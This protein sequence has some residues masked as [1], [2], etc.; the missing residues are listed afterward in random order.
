MNCESMT[1]DERSLLLYFEDCMV[2][3]MC[4]VQ[5]VHMNEEDFRIAEKWHEDKFV[6]FVRCPYDFIR[7]DNPNRRAGG[8]YTHLVLLSDEAW[9]LAHQL[10]EERGNRQFSNIVERRVNGELLIP[11]IEKAMDNLGLVRGVAWGEKK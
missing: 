8:D 7:K 3:K 10:R 1:K 9:E 2:N 4:C 11:A 6:S 5:P